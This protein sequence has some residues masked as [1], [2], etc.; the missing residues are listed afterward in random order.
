MTRQER[1]SCFRFSTAPTHFA[2][3]REMYDSV[4]IVSV[5]VLH[6]GNNLLQEKKKRGGGIW[7]QFGIVQKPFLFPLTTVFLTIDLYRVWMAFPRILGCH[8]CS[9]TELFNSACQCCFRPCFLGEAFETNKG[10]SVIS[11]WSLNFCIFSKPWG[12]LNTLTGWLSQQKTATIRP[13]P[14]NLTAYNTL[15]QPELFLSH[16]C[17]LVVHPDMIWQ[18]PEGNQVQTGKRKELTPKCIP[19]IYQKKKKNWVR[20]SGWILVCTCSSPADHMYLCCER[21]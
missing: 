13:G 8:C 21:I 1:G 6:F 18:R 4:K 20:R 15:K 11:R 17:T 9:W 12:V 5:S 19:W 10:K 3:Q 2:L 7:K 16:C 14:Q